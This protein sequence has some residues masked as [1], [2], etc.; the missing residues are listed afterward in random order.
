M[1]S[2]SD[3][4]RGSGSRAASQAIGEGRFDFGMSTPSI[5]ILQTI[6]GPPTVALAARAYDATMG[7]GVLNGGHIRRPARAVRDRGG[8]VRCGRTRRGAGTPMLWQA[9]TPGRGEIM[10]R[11]SISRPGFLGLTDKI[12]LGVSDWTSVRARVSEF[13]KYL[14]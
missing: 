1:G 11:R 4:A 10:M 14:S 7:I 12:R 5:A 8:A 3:I 13:D 2:V 9:M 6:K